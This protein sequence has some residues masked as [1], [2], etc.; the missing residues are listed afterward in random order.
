MFMHTFIVTWM[1]YITDM[2]SAVEKGLLRGNII[3][4]GYSLLAG[5]EVIDTRK[6]VGTVSKLGSPVASKTP[7]RPSHRIDNQHSHF[8]FCKLHS[9][10]YPPF[11]T[12]YSAST[13]RKI[14]VIDFPHSTFRIPTLVWVT[15][16]L[17]NTAS[18]PP[19]ALAT[20]TA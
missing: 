9:A 19:S 8:A 7:V 20:S 3:K 1:N 18:A 5:K 17:R 16:V 4:E 11:R 13:F 6:R 15:T 12:C 2:H 10:F 14:P